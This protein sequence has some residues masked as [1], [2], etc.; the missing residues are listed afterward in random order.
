MKAVNLSCGPVNRCNWVEQRSFNWIIFDLISESRLNCYSR[1]PAI[2]LSDEELNCFCWS[3]NWNKSS[4]DYSPV[5]NT[6]SHQP[7][8]NRSFAVNLASRK[9]SH[10]HKS[11]SL[12]PAGAFIPSCFS[13]FI[14][15]HKKLPSIV[16]SHARM[17][18]SSSQLY[19]LMT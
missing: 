1:V 8:H 4:F 5:R 2:N 11:F 14:F 18:Q 16:A 10:A 9:P 15:L 7:T 19:R 12:H 3:W 17:K 13:H 6:S